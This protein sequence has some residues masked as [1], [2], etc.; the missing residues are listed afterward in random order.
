MVPP[1]LSKLYIDTVFPARDVSLMHT[2]VLGLA[3]FTITSAVVGAVRSYYTQVTT[4]TLSNAVGLMSFNHLQHL[5]I[6]FFEEHPVGEITSRLGEMRGAL[7]LVSRVFQTVIVNGV[8]LVLVP[9]FL[10]LLS[11]QLA[12]LSLLS[13]PITTA[14]TA[15]TSRYVRRDIRRSAELGAEMGA[16]QVEALSQIRTLKP[17]AV[18]SAVFQE[19][20]KQSEDALR[21]Q[22]R[23]AGVTS[24]VGIINS[25]VRA[26]AMA[27]F[28]WYAW[29]L[30]LANNLTLGSFF[31]FSAYLGYLTG[32]VAAFAGLFTD[33]QVM[34]VNLGRAFEYLDIAPEQ[35]PSLAYESPPAI[36]VLIR[37]DL[38]LENVSFAYSADRPTLQDVTFKCFPGTVTAVVGES[39]A[40]K[41]TMLRLICRMSGVGSGRISLDGI[42]IEQIPLPDLR[43]QVAVVSQEPTLLRGT[44]LQNLTFGLDGVSAADVDEAIRLCQL[45]QLISELPLGYET[46]IA[47]WGAS[48][49]GGQ[50]QRFAI[51]RALLRNAPVLLLDEAT[52]QM[53]VRTEEEVL[54]QVMAK[55]RGKTVL[56]VTHRLATAALADQIV[57]MQRG[58]VVGCGTHQEL[59]NDNVLYRGMLR[60]DAVVPGLH[61]RQRLGG[62]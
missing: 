59:S 3:A 14:I 2:L 9:P 26:A 20:R 39:G 44:I 30:I 19:A 52:S 10:F 51:A 61:P 46:P 58:R 13:I 22:L 23:A 40:G 32:P 36:A 8:Y 50:R 55:V 18:E 45:T 48:V 28:T 43:R 12:V 5:P 35:D 42:G 11:W 16:I 24:I 27:V 54:G 57:V 17:M 21:A 6:K 62:A 4:S 38:V 33:L 1:Y 49:S 34:S 29:T 41:S 53:D 60:G 56:M 37:G 15:T 31:A 25:G 47:E 7:G